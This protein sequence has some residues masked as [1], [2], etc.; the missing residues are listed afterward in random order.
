MT[1]AFFTV[2]RLIKTLQESAIHVTPT[3][4]SIASQLVQTFQRNR[5]NANI[6]LTN[7]NKQPH[8][9]RTLAM[10]PMFLRRRRNQ[11]RTLGRN[12]VTIT[13]RIK[14]RIAGI[15]KCANQRRLN[16]TTLDFTLHGYRYPPQQPPPNQKP[17]QRHPQPTHENRDAS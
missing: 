11:M 10:H 15:N 16:R 2:D 13:R 6:P 9:L 4:F 17:Y 14:M 8:K 3:S 12:N 5:L 7:R 1:R